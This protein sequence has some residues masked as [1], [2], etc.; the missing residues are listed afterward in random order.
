[1]KKE[2]QS[3]DLRIWNLVK[4]EL[5]SDVIQIDMIDLNGVVGMQGGGLIANDQIE[6][7]PITEEWLG[8]LGFNHNHDLFVRGLIMRYIFSYQI[9]E[10]I[11]YERLIDFKIEFVHELQNLYFALTGEELELKSET[12]P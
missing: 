1:M 12:K 10:L 8:I 5:Y 4:S 6:P 3:K 2:L 7:I 11:R 9:I